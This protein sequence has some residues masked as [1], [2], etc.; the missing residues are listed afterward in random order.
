MDLHIA[1]KQ[2]APYPKRM[3][4]KMSLFEG[5]GSMGSMGKDELNAGA[6]NESYD[7][8]PDPNHIEIANCVYEEEI[9]I[10]S[11][12]VTI[13][14]MIQQVYD[15]KTWLK[16]HGRE[17]EASWTE[18]IETLGGIVQDYASKARDRNNSLK[19]L[20]DERKA[21]P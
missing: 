17:L 6:R 2:N 3:E 1:R 20:L 18:D 8:N 4:N 13:A 12:L 19:E 21:R 14:P 15:M 10:A 5:T 16:N 7:I 11:I 9:A